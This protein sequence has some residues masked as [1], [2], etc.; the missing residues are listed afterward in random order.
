MDQSNLNPTVAVLLLNF[1]QWRVTLDCIE[2][3][4]QTDYNRYKIFLIDNG[5][6]SNEDYYNLKKIESDSCKVVRLDKNR[7]YVGGM[8]YGLEIASQE[9]FDFFLVMNNDTIIAHD[10]ISA[11][12]ECSLRNGGRCIVTGK[13]YDFEKPTVIQHIG[14]KIVNKNYLKMKRIVQ[15][16]IDNGQW[17]KEEEMDMIDDIF[18][19]LPSDVYEKI[20][21]YSPYFWFNAEQADLAIRAKNSG[22][23]LIYTPKARLWH[24]GSISVGGRINNPKFVF[25]D[26][27]G[28]LLLRFIHLP[29]YRFF[30]LVTL[31][32]LR[33]FKGI[34][35]NFAKSVLGYETKFTLVYAELMGI[36]WVILWIFKRN[37]NDG[38]TPFDK[39]I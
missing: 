27:Q 9:G 37:N 34:F 30:I 32:L 17:D 2:S 39:S 7:G 24:K 19:L 26:I 4:F 22:Y 38:K 5:S 6:F 31:A 20:G 35:K 15:D 12:V 23:K 18:W 10:A 36:R 33:V 1:N 21:G 8:N 14:F 29:F 16:Q 28:S 13:V 3:L 25:Y 11:L